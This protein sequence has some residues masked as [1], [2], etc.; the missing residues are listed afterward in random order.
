MAKT[1]DR[2]EFLRLAGVGGALF[3]SGL[4]GCAGVDM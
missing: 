3:A 2:R 1:I 4:A